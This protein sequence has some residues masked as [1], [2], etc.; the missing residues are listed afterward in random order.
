MRMSLGLPTH[1][2]DALEE[3]AGAD[4]IAEVSVAAETAGFDAVFVTDHPMPADHWLATGGH[5]TLDPFVALTFAAAATTRI[6]L[7]TNLLILA[8]RNPFLSAKAVASL[9]ALSG[10]RMIVGVGAGYLAGEFAALGVDFDERNDLTDESITTMRA[11][12]SGESVTVAGRHFEATGNT[13]LPRPAQAG[14]PT[15]WIGGNSKRA[16]RRAVELADGWMPMPSP[17][18]SERRL[19]TPAITSL[20]DF[21]ERL[22]FARDHAASVGRTEPFEV[23]FMPMGLDMFS[24]AGVKPAA[25]VESI[26][27]LAAAGATYVT[28]MV[29]GDTRAEFLDHV[30]MFGDEII[31]QVAKL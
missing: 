2:V 8:Y 1:R 16:I 14:G 28:M 23:V 20:A 3:L 25:V 11:A 7:Q 26:E 12:W 18:G 22:G 5:H 21:A 27:Q 17:A 24:N 4:A 6:R 31:P 13:M 10:G 30:S 9:D 19:K 29:P 15:I